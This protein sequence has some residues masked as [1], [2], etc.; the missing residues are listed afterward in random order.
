MNGPRSATLRSFDKLRAQGERLR[1][2]SVDLLPLDLPLRQPFVTALGSKRVSRNLLV[3]VHLSD[4]TAGAGEASASLAWP[5]QN[6]AAMKKGLAPLARRF[7][8]RAIG[9]YR[10]LTAETWEQLPR[11][12]T[13]AA[14]LECALLD[15]YTR[16]RGVSLWK[17]F[18]GKRR[19]V[20][21]SLTLSA[22]PAPLAARTAKRAYASG[23]RTLKVKLT[24]RDF[25]GDLKRLLAVHRAAPKAALWL[26][27]NQGFTREQALR[28]CAETARLRLPAELFEQPVPRGQW[29]AFEEIERKTGLPVAADES[30]RSVKETAELIRRRAALAV[31]VKLAKCGIT[32]AL[33]IIRL[34]KK[35]GVWLMIGCMAE[36]AQGLW[37]SIALAAGTGAFHY[38]D[39]DSHLLNVSPPCPAFRTRGQELLVS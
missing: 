11:L 30:A 22:W 24:G 39:L 10:R 13:A 14:A 21:T 38:I 31:N 17:W 12:H 32:G 19:S 27:G 26:D 16:S 28:F 35:H 37:P 7:T 36:S 29:R 33:E 4:G 1:I 2:T 18:G 34:A 20:T 6:R 3:V 23:F 8:G 9:D 15:A 25:D 5:D